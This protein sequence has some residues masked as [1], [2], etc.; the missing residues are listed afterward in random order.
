MLRDNLHGLE[1]D[2]RCTQIAAFALAFAAWKSDGYRTLPLPH[3]ACSGIAISGSLEQWRKLA[4]GD[5][6]LETTLERLYHL[7]K[8]APTLG[9]LIDPRSVSASDP[10]FGDAVVGVTRA[11]SLLAGQYTLVATNVPYLAQGKQDERLTRFAD[12]N[13]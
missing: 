5:L 11:A 7:F 1:L 9:S 10:L 3:V 13:H 6:R 2:P 4:G 12:T 8:D